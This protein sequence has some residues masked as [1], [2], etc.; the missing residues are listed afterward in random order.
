M[1]LS[2]FIVLTVKVIASNTCKLMDKASL[3]HAILLNIGHGIS[4][5]LSATLTINL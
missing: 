4:L 5:I 2:I 3:F 1:F